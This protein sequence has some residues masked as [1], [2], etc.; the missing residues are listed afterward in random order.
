MSDT[1]QA[2]V[3]GGCGSKDG[4]AQG[5]H[6]PG[7]P[8]VAEERLRRRRLEGLEQ[9]QQLQQHREQEKLLRQFFAMGGGGDW[10]EEKAA[11][12]TA[13]SGGHAEGAGTVGEAA[14]TRG[15][16]RSSSGGTLSALL[17]YPD[18]LTPPNGDRARG[19]AAGSIGRPA[20]LGP[21]GL[22][23]ST[24]GGGGG[25]VLSPASSAHSNNG[26]ASSPASSS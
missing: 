9:Q 26:F 11:R 15:C 7:R 20:S 3:N 16:R 22:G 14:H 8:T 21:G 10:D 5:L 1:P 2:G 18:P 19:L 4:Q 17:G 13:S 25:L 24:G 23:V 12:A 6:Q